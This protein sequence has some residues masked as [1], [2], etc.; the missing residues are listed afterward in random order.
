MKLD[1]IR[2]KNETEGLLLSIPKNCETPIKTTHKKA[3]ES[4]EFKLIKPGETFSSKPPISFEGSWMIGLTDLE[5]YNS[6]CNITHENKEFELYT[7]TFDEFSIEDLKDELEQI[8][9]IS[10]ITNEHLQDKTLGPHINSTYRKL[11]TEKRL[12]NGY[13]MLLMGYARSPFRDFESYHRIVVGIAQ[14]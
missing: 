11:E 6:I 14:K 3:E 12:T 13:Y 2:P 5:V 1:M 10:K 7:D 8:L 4:S 9:N